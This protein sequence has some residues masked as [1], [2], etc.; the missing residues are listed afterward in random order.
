MNV[1]SLLQVMKQS[2]SPFKEKVFSQSLNFKHVLESQQSGNQ[3]FKLGS[4]PFFV[5]NDTLPQ[6]TIELSLL[7]D[8]LTE[9]SIDLNS[10]FYPE[11]MTQE[12]EVIDNQILTNEIRSIKGQSNSV[13]DLLNKVHASPIAV[14]VFA[15]AEVLQSMPTDQKMNFAPYLTK[16]NEMLENEYPSYKNSDAQLSSMISAINKIDSN[17]S[18]I[19]NGQILLEKWLTTDD[20]TN[21]V[22]MEKLFTLHSN[23]V[24]NTNKV[25]LQKAHIKS[26]FLNELELESTNKEIVTQIKVLLGNADLTSFTKIIG[27]SVESILYETNTIAQKYKFDVNEQFMTVDFKNKSNSFIFND[28]GIERKNNQSKSVQSNVEVEQAVQHILNPESIKEDLLDESKVLFE[29]RNIVTDLQTEIKNLT[30]DPENNLTSFIKVLTSLVNKDSNNKKEN[31]KIEIELNKENQQIGEMLILDRSV[32]DELGQLRIESSNIHNF[33][34]IAKIGRKVAKELIVD[35]NEVLTA[36]DKNLYESNIQNRLHSDENKQHI[37]SEYQIEVKQT[38]APVVDRVQLLI[39]EINRLSSNQLLDMPLINSQLNNSKVTF[40]VSK[41]SEFLDKAIPLTDRLIAIMTQQNEKATS[42][43]KSTLFAENGLGIQDPNGQS[44]E[45]NLKAFP[46]QQF[47]DIEL[48][49]HQMNRSFN[50]LT[51]MKTGQSLVQLEAESSMKQ[52]FINPITNHQVFENNLTQQSKQIID[53]EDVFL[54]QLEKLVGNQSSLS[55]ETSKLDTTVKKEFTNH[56]IHAFKGSKFTQLANGANR[57]VINLN[58]E[59]LGNLTVRL[60][61]KNGEMVARIIA[62]TESAKELLE[63]SVHQLKQ[64]LPTMQ[65]EI[66]RFEVYTEQSTKTF[67][68][69]SEEKEQQKNNPHKSRHEEEKETEQSFIESLIDALDTSV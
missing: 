50:K 25:T 2:E 34:N 43:I 1:A 51:T 26:E 49:Q 40:S 52:E 33:L 18:T 30:E 5:A 56:L 32:V 57:L 10:G 31:L 3:V 55:M 6:N 17:D 35:I 22:K 46:K 41:L 9:R 48:F 28:K 42:Q 11:V 47:V 24:N 53:K 7:F 12:I 44:M 16:L 61:Q 37:L 21:L 36:I 29:I 14:G 62:S 68:E 54:I 67:R 23:L 13:E 8:E 63:H 39:E 66:E 59:H 69:N 15:L 4:N 60:V 58:P 27:K 20:A 45:H 38:I 65:V 64:V 19:L